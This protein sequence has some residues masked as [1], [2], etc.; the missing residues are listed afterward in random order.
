MQVQRNVRFVGDLR[1]GIEAASD[2]LDQVSSLILRV[3]DVQRLMDVPNPM[4]EEDERLGTILIAGGGL[5]IVRMFLDCENDAVLVTG[6]CRDVLH[7]TID[8]EEVPI[9]ELLEVNPGAGLFA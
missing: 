8:V 4:P 5:Q 2:R 1:D 6:A 9:V 7:R 3:A